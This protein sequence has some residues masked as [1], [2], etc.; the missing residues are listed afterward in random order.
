MENVSSTRTVPVE[1]K[2]ANQNNT[3]GTIAALAGAQA[4]SMQ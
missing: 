3:K 1:N 2:R 4:V